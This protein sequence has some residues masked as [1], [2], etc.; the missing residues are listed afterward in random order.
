MVCFK[1]LPSFFVTGCIH[2]SCPLVTK[3]AGKV[4]KPVSSATSTI[5]DVYGALSSA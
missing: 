5:L 1:D 4:P 2:W 3:G